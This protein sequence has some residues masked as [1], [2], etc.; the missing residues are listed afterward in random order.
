MVIAFVLSPSVSHAITRKWTGASG[1]FNWGTPGNWDPAGI[2]DGS[3]TAY[4][5]GDGVN[6]ATTNN[7][8]RFLLAMSFTVDQTATVTVNAATNRYIS[9]TAGGTV[10]SVAAGSHTFIGDGTNSCPDWDIKFQGSSTYDISSGA[11]FEIQGRIRQNSTNDN[12]TKIGGGTL[13]LSGPNG[14]SSAWN[15]TGP[16]SFFDVQQGILRF[17]IGGAQGNSGNDFS[18]SSGAALELSG[19]ATY[20]VNNGNF[21]LNGTGIGGNGALRSISGNNTVSSSGTGTITL[22]TASSIGVDGGSTLTLG[23][24]IAGA[25]ALTKVG[26]GELR[27]SITNTY[28]G[29]TTISAGTLALSGSGSI[30]NSPNLTVGSGGTFDV[31]GLTA[32]LTLLSS[33][34]LKASAT[35]ADATGSITVA[36]GKNLTLSSGGL[37]FTAYGGGATAPLTVNGGSAGELALNGAPITV[38]TTTVLG[39]GL[40]KLIGKSGSAAVTGTPGTLTINGSGIV[41]Q[42]RATLQLVSGELWLEVRLNGTL[43]LIE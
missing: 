5:N 38:T 28:S 31:S 11:A 36:S 14:G 40:H 20:T 13:I 2:P 33:Q 29:N 6:L 34:T 7:S 17:T 24:V 27:L 9:F 21:T 32:G 43:Y 39:T 41:D 25:N 3:D 37:A 35:G 8:S 42:A 12:Y 4:F 15:F 23:K 10:I 19:N 22:A 18:V 1:N 30:S 16:S 26:S